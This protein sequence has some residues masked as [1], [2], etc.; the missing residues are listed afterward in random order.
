M[1]CANNIGRGTKDIRIAPKDRFFPPRR[2]FREDDWPEELRDA[3]RLGAGDEL[4]VGRFAKI[5]LET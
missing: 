2:R 4:R 1:I 3:R 5:V